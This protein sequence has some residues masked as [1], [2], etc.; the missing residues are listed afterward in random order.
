M[1]ECL[2]VGKS[3]KAIRVARNAVNLEP[4]NAGLVA[5]LALALLIGA[6]LDEAA[7]TVNK[8][9][10]MAP[11]DQI[12]HNLKQRIADVKCGS[13]PQPVKMSDLD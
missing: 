5:N 7:E 1:F 9:L 2:N 13:I 8:A 12:S 11:D 10:A 6:E 4:E 3:E